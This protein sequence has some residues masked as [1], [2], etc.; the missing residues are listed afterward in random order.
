MM[1]GMDHVNFETFLNHKDDYTHHHG[2]E[3]HYYGRDQ[4]QTLISQSTAN[5]DDFLSPNKTAIFDYDHFFDNDD[6]IF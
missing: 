5:L 3:S 1:R 6:E 2:Y 4:H